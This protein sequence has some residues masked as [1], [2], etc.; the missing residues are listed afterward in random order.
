MWL[1]YNIQ[2]Q[3]ESEF[4]SLK[5]YLYETKSKWKDDKCSEF[6]KRHIDDMI[7]LVDS[8]LMCTDKLVQH[9]KDVDDLLK[10]SNYV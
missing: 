3:K 10:R 5:N 9:F 1:D 6:F 2:K 7:S 4:K 8:F